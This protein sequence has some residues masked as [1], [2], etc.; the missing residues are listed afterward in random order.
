[1]VSTPFFKVFYEK[2]TLDGACKMGHKAFFID[3]DGGFFPC[4]FR[5]GMKLKNYLGLI[6]ADF[7]KA[8]R[9]QYTIIKNQCLS[10]KCINLF[11]S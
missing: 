7:L 6:K 10:R 3:S 4:P 5:T 8:I 1:M 2:A 11:V 9:N